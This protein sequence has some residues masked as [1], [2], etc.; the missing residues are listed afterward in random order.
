MTTRPLRPLL[1]SWSECFGSILRP[2]WAVYGTRTESMALSEVLWGKPGPVLCRESFINVR[3]G[4]LACGKF[5]HK[6]IPTLG[7]FSGVEWL[8]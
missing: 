7:L 8:F 6:H 2:H 1:F 5:L 4:D 3:E